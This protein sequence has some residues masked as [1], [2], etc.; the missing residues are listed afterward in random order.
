VTTRGRY[1][2]PAKELSLVDER[3]RYPIHE[4]DNVPEIEAHE[5]Q[6][7]YCRDALK[8]HFPDRYVGGNLCIY[9]ERGNTRHYIAPDVFVAAGELAKPKPRVYLLWED[10][11]V[12]FVLEVISRETTR[13]GEKNR[14]S[15]GGICRRR[16]CWR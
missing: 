5:A 15:T 11:P 3:D 14:A 8:A 9:W 7:R 10:P 1:A 12:R 16:R 6:V 4:E 2:V 13:Q